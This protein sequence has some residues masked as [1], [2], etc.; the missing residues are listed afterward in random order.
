M[1][2]KRFKAT[3]RKRQIATIAASLFAKRGFNGV[4][5][6]EIARKAKVN[7]AIL[8][9]HFPTKEALYDEIINQKVKA[10]LEFIDKDAAERCDDTRVFRS[11]ALNMINLVEK[12]STFLR[13][14][15]YSALGDHRLAGR[16]L[17]RTNL[18]FEPIL[19][20]IK[21]RMD[22]GVFRKINPAAALMAFNGMIFHFIMT[23]KLYKIPKKYIVS[24]E[25]AVENFVNIF[26]DGMQRRGR[27]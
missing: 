9:R 18:P 10:E 12:D 21:R 5:T 26:L 11:I 23:R 27:R 3:E 2:P 17:N 1:R 24:K 20:Y 8:F 15:L 16:F 22:E 4:T 13:L 19:Q 6:R 14:M 25:S 7:E